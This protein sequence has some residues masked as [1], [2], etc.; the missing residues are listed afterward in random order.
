M[1]N[2]LSIALMAL[3]LC[4]AAA[5]CSSSERVD[6]A[7]APDNAPPTFTPPDDADGSTTD[8]STS[9]HT[10][11]C[12]A[13]ECYAPWGTC[14]STE[15]PTY[16]C[17]TNLSN[18]RDNCGSCGNKCLDY[19]PINLIGSCVD[20]ACQTQCYKHFSLLTNSF[21]DW[22]DC[23]GLIEDGCEIDRFNDPNNCGQCGNACA[24]GAPC[25]DGKC[26]C[27]QGLTL[28]DGKCVDAQWDDF[29]CGT[30]GNAC[31]LPGD[32][33]DPFETHST[34]GCVLGQ[35]GK[36]KCTTEQNTQWTDCNN[37]LIEHQC[38][39]DGCETAGLKSRENCG[40]CGNKCVGAEECVNEGNGYECA[41]PC[42]RV[43]KVLC[44]STCVDLLTD[45]DNCGTCGAGCRPPGFD[46]ATF[47]EL[48]TCEKGLCVYEC[49]PGFGDCNGDPSDG[50]ETNLNMNQLNCGT[51]GNSCD[52]TAGQPCIEGKCLTVDCDGGVPN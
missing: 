19:Q 32:A 42:E 37:D 12:M 15:K 52:V 49:M 34:Y 30:C 21:Q 7:S 6:L 51:C 50:C 10:L 46:D 3:G 5:S 48:S 31:E 1:K 14:A 43:G 39:G 29:N 47:N 33:C 40:R 45:R 27:P 38:G 4:A 11:Q 9:T 24:P 41:I 22:S 36:K 16:K 13:T 8:G 18:D 25:T 44:G 23:N 17:G 20:S 28:C 35:C 26:G 2:L